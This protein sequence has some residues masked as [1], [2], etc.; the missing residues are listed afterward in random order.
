VYLPD[1]YAT[2][3]QSYSVFY[4]LHGSSG[5]EHDWLVKGKVEATLDRLIAERRIPPTI[6]VMPG[7]KGMW[8]VDGNGEKAET[9]L[10][11]ELLPDVQ[12][13]FRTIAERAGRAVGGLSAGGY[14]T[15]RLAFTHPEMFAAGAALSPAVYDPVPPSNSAAVKD[16]AFQKDGAFDATTWQR[17]NWP[18]LF[19]AYKSQPQVVPLYLNSGDRDRFDIAYHAAALHKTL[20]G[21]QPGMVV[22]RVVDGDHEWPVWER[23]IGEAM[24]Y[25]LNKLS[26]PQKPENAPC[27]SPKD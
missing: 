15:I 26:G 22:F 7:H 25:T 4:L 16:P 21:H 19:E 12:A 2:S 5:D 17:L 14:G 23:T 8:W 3:C 11:K 27:P 13:R 6:V 1:G 9:V 24:E 10:L 20:R 18:G